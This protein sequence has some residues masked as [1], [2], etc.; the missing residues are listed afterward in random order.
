MKRDSAS[1]TTH[2]K[3]LSTRIL[4]FYNSK[5]IAKISTYNLRL[6]TEIYKQQN[7]TQQEHSPGDFGKQRTWEANWE[8]WNNKYFYK[9][10]IVTKFCN[11]YNALLSS[12]GGVC[13]K[14]YSK[15]QYFR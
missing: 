6:H 12:T 1:H 5:Q 10:L 3:I 8:Y 9:I 7:A 2:T 13:L 4:V 11:L 15:E 14:L